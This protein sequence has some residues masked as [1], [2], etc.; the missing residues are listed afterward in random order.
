M[1]CKTRLNN[2]QIVNQ[3]HSNNHKIRVIVTT[4]RKYMKRHINF[5]VLFENVNEINIMRMRI[6]IN[7]NIINQQ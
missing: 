5:F 7:F 3:I 1:F 6:N 2:N 4:R